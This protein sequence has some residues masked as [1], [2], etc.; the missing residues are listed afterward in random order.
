MFDILETMNLLVN[1]FLV[2][3]FKIN[4]LKK[5]DTFLFLPPI[6]FITHL[7]NLNSDAP[8]DFTEELLI[9]VSC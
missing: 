6:Q 2:Q 3:F 5:V 8:Q 9:D 4:F 1:R 7:L